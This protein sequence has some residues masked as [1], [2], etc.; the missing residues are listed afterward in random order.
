[1]KL[2]I[3][4]GRQGNFILAI[5]L[6][7]FLFFG[8][9]CNKYKKSIGDRLLFLHQVIFNPESILSLIILI[10]IVFFMVFRE[11]FLEFGIR[12]SFW[13]SFIIIG[14][15]FIWYGIVY[16]F[17]IAIIAKFFTRYEGY[18]TICTLLSINMLTAL[19][20]G[21]SRKKYDESKRY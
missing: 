8:Y 1:M 9:L 19:L 3:E 10:V 17:D 12:N 16:S 4:L 18:L 2:N 21:L 5:L 15:S 6:S 14:M 7:Y 11:K 20:A 13:L